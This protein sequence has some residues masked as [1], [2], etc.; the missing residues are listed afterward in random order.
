MGLHR[1]EKTKREI[2]ANK[3][4]CMICFGLFVS[5]F[6]AKVRGQFDCQLLNGMPNAI[7]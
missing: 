6:L 7:R 1:R 3:I 4:F 2:E 5:I